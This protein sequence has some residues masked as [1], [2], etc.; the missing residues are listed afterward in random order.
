MSGGELET[1]Y[2]LWGRPIGRRLLLGLGLGLLFS[3]FALAFGFGI[4][5]DS[6]KHWLYAFGGSTE[7]VAILLI[8]SPELAPHA[9]RFLLRPLGPLGLHKD[10]RATLSDAGT[11]F[12]EGI[13]SGVETYDWNSL[14]DPQKIERLHELAQGLRKEDERLR[15]ELIRLK[16]EMDRGLQETSEEMDTR[17]VERLEKHRSELLNERFVGV[18][19]LL[20][21]ILLSTWANLL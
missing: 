15:S 14:E 1:M 19:L 17:S 12:S 6:G 11:I 13:V 7:F 8:A 4:D 2:R 18:A 10:V 20:F 9:E 21:G 5:G 3:L 16:G